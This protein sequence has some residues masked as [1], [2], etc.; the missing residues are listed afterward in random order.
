MSKAFSL[1]QQKN[2][3]QNRGFSCAVVAMDKVQSS[4]RFKYH[5]LDDA[6]ILYLDAIDFHRLKTVI[7]SPDKDKMKRGVF[8]TP[9]P[10]TSFVA[11]NAIGG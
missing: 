2:C 4:S 3:F 7:E 9:L 5:I 10:R 8:I 6:H 11:D 1:P